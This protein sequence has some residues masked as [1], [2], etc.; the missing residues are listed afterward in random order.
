MNDQERSE[1]EQLRQMHSLMQ[2]E[3]QVLGKRLEALES[4]KRAEG[5]AAV[6]AAAGVADVPPVI[7]HHAATGPAASR[8][9]SVAA[10]PHPVLP[11]SPVSSAALTRSA[12]PNATPAAQKTPSPTLTERKV[13]PKDQIV[14]APAPAKP[15]AGSAGQLLQASPASGA[16]TGPTPTGS[17][18][19]R[20]GTYW[21]VRLGVV[22]LLTGL[23][24]FGNLAYQ[25]F[26]SKLGPGGK[27][28]LLYLASF[29][30][31][32]IGAWWQRQAARESLR[33]YAQ[34]LF[35]G[36]LAAGYFTTYAAHHVRNLRII[37]D[38]LVDGVLLLLWAGFMAWIADRKKSEVLALFAIGLAYYTS[39]MTRVGT[40]TLLSNTILTAAAVF[41]LVRNRWAA[42]SYASVAATYLSYAF[43]RFFDGSAWRL[44]SP[45]EGLWLGTWFLTC[46]WALF[47]VAVFLS[48][49]EKL[50]GHNRAA[51]L[52]LNNG[53][54]LAMF[55]LTMALSRQGGL[56]AFLLMYGAVLL[57][58]SEAARA[59][60]PEERLTRQAYLVQGLV[61]FT[62]GLVAK[63]SGVQLALMLAAESVVLL[64]LGLGSVLGTQGAG[65]SREGVAGT[66]ALP[67]Q[68]GV[69]GILR[70]GAMAAAAM[71]VGS[72]CYGLKRF[73]TPTLFMGM[74][75]GVLVLANALLSHRAAVR[76]PSG[77]PGALH[78]L[79]LY[80]AI[81]AVFMWVATTFQNSSAAM[82]PLLL[83]A[84]G[85]LLTLSIYA[86]GLTEL[87]LCGQVLLAF[88]SG[89]WLLRTA[90]AGGAPWWSFALATGVNVAMGHWWTR[91]RVLPLDAALSQN[92]S[93][94]GETYSA[95]PLP[96]T[97]ALNRSFM[98]VML[99]ISA[100]AVVAAIYT[101][102][103][104]QVTRDAWV[105]LAA[106]LGLALS[107]YGLVTRAWMLTGFGQLL[108]IGGVVNFMGVL[109]EGR[110]AWYWTVAPL[111]VLGVLGRGTQLWFERHPGAGK[112]VSEPVLGLATVYLWVGTLTSIW[113]IVEYTPAA[114][115]AWV[116]GLV[117]AGV[118][119]AGMFRSHQGLLL[120]SVPYTAVALCLLWFPVFGTP[121]V[122]W[123]N[124]FALLVLVTEQRLARRFALRVPIPPVAH[125]VAI[126]SVA[127]SFWLYVSRWVLEFA[128]GFYLTV[129]WSALALILFVMGM[130]FRERIYRWTGL[131]VLG[132]ALGRVILFDVWKLGTVNRMLSFLALGVVL[133]VLGF[134][135]NRYQEKIR[136]WL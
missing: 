28:S 93:A 67:S 71:A 33:N 7:A 133:L 21:L 30:M 35:A 63:L 73:D 68:A 22:M 10:R 56:W 25:N 8:P 34:V 31:I 124:L 19:M 76:R 134:V 62:A 97:P 52:T 46:Y 9:E 106:V 102:V 123:P 86:L 85:V 15:E 116:L 109:W 23:V 110:P 89:G 90:A 20:L 42:L 48:R 77:S 122:Y 128:G 84:E 29:A 14:L 96:A 120:F 113:W 16:T 2:A 70:F 47:T 95:N 54:F 32:G 3:L 117:G 11:H 98:Q 50:S 119:A 53:A 92:A 6:R 1:L 36:G 59:F 82:F 43:W 58:L 72:A 61:L 40:F 107:I 87:L 108:V 131:G 49:S 27:V 79:P 101:W 39:I 135:Y 130:T 115:R 37:G 126:L 74:G 65:E 129:S 132:F 111:L 125:T 60:L 51:F 83:L 127:V 100:L 5:V 45:E 18:E 91:Q 104:A 41:F 69:S 24:F 78:P 112:N 17:F 12:S 94:T 81:A 121:M 75:V 103:P 80:F 105:L 38:P 55:L 13:I 44:A 26:I 88:G 114:H 99:A 57:A 136:Q 118:F 64:G 66:A 4:R